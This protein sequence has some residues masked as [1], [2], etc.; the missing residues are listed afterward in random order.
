MLM[1]CRNSRG[2][3]HDRDAEHDR[4]LGEAVAFAQVFVESCPF[5][6]RRHIGDLI[7]GEKRKQNFRCRRSGRTFAPYVE[8]PEYRLGY[9]HCAVG[10]VLA[11]LEFPISI[12]AT[13]PSETI[14]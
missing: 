1:R 7:A 9:P 3:L 2:P 12:S 14:F 8:N 13:V 4:R 5:A 10:E 11:H 6:A